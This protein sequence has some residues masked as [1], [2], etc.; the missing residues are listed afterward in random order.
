[1]ARSANLPDQGAPRLNRHKCNVAVG[2]F[3]NPCDLPNMKFAKAIGMI[4]LTT[5]LALAVI[6]RVPFLRN[7]TNPPAA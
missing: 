7:L 4:V 6:N 1:M 2:G 3:L 5:A